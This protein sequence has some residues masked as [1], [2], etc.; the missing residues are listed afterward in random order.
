MPFSKRVPHF[1]DDANWCVSIG[2]HPERYRC[3]LVSSVTGKRDQLDIKPVGNHTGFEQFVLGPVA[4]RYGTASTMV[5]LTEGE[6][7]RLV[8]TKQ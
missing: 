5:P 2:R 8:D 7:I 3:K 6:Q 4:K 1:V